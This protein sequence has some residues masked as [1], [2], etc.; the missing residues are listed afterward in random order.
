MKK[1]IL[2][3]LLSLFLASCGSS[4]KTTET[5]VIGK[6]TT[7]VSSKR[8]SKVVNHA[9][10]FKGTRYKFGGTDKRGMD[11]SG[12]VYTSYKSENIELPRV[13]RDMA[14]KGIRIK[15]KEVQKGDLVFFKT[16]KNRNVINHVGLVVESRSGDIQFIHSTSSRGVI[17]SSLDEKY[18]K[19]AFVEVRRII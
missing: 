13:S 17:V 9:Q 15:L 5:V 19:N 2:I 3:S 1:L 12:L 4:R 11:C 6:G 16:N 8:I 7:A 18:W 14:K 10:T